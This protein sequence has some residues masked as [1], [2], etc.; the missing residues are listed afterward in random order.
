VTDA[1]P[2]ETSQPE[3]DNHFHELLAAHA[4]A[5]QTMHPELPASVFN[6]GSYH[7]LTEQVASALEIAKHIRSQE[8]QHR[9][10]ALPRAAPS[11]ER[12][13][14]DWSGMTA[15]EKIRAGLRSAAG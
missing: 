10:I 5:L 11:G 7:Q 2:N 1:P 15:G 9:V 12:Q 4:A 14:A 13:T 8:R 6:A 3:P